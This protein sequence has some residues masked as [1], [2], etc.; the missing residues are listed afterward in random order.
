MPTDLSDVH[1]DR[2][3]TNVQNFVCDNR[4]IEI[5]ELMDEPK[6]VDYLT[7][8]ESDEGNDFEIPIPDLNDLLNEFENGDDVL[9]K[10]EEDFS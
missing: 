3:C 2:K 10:E 5:P 6:E 4:E 9:A 1:R 7:D 8:D